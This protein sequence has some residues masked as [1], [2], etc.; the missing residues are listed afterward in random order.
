M[1]E[2]TA[3]RIDAVGALRTVVEGTASETG[4]PF[5][6]ALVQNLARALDTRGAWITEYLPAVE[7]LRTLAFWFGDGWLEPFEYEFTGTPCEVAIREARMIHIPARVSDLYPGPAPAGFP[8]GEVSYL[9]IPLLDTD[10]RVL[11]HVGV[12]DTR[13]M[14]DENGLVP[15]FE[16]FA[17]RAAAEMRRLRLE[18]ELR[19]RR[20][21]LERLIGSTMDAIVELDGALQI[22]RLNSAAEK[23]FS[24]SGSEVFGQSIEKLLGSESARRLETLARDLDSRLEHERSMWI[25]GGLMAQPSGQ[26]E[27][28]A[29]A[30][31]SR[32]EMRGEPFYTLILRNVNERAEAE[33]TIESLSARAEYLREELEEDHGFDEILGRSPS[34]RTALKSV[35]QVAATDAT[36]LLLGET[37]T[38]KELFARAIHNRS[39][40]HERPLIK[41]NCAAIPAALIESEF[42][43]HE[44]GAFTGATQRREGRFALADGGT[45]FLDEIGELPLELQGKL[46]RVLQEGEF[47]PVGGSRTR[48][49]D[50]RVLAATNRDLEQCVRRGAFR[51]DLYYRLSVFPLRLPPLRERGDDVVL[52]AEGILSRLSRRMAKTVDPLSPGDI[53]ALKSYAWPGNVRELRNVIERALIT[54]HGRTIH[55]E[56]VLPVDSGALEDSAVAATA[57]ADPA[58]EVLSA[59]RMRE[60]DRANM[61]AALERSGWR[62]G[63]GG[64]AADL[65]GLQPSTFKSRMKA[66][67]IERPRKA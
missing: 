22:T 8:A 11:G 41:V 57:M 36:V 47:E 58:S 15:L 45:I 42:F 28:P 37:G 52:L 29:E 61:L 60:I 62:V 49:V 53:A 19:D 30:T 10:R 24:R 27:F 13:S 39:A 59:R 51:E 50:I 20:E 55:L 66:L 12:V 40:R 16:I 67:G 14:P 44:R 43:G 56:R 25:P 18:G 31:L 33:R 21:K 2:Q 34:L 9:G 48:K 1:A 63:G 35:S 54:A 17:T 5:Y 32:F 38:G 64:G 3:R 23:T 6:R 65:L 26:S 4:E 46:L 7:R